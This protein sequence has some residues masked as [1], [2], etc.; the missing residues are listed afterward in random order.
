MLAFFKSASLRDEVVRCR[1]AIN[2]ALVSIEKEIPDL[3]CR[4]RFSV[5][6]I[7]Q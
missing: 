6:T 4:L 1:L 2:E 7:F 3:V 5:V